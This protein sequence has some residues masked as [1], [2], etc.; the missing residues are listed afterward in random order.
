MAKPGARSRPRRGT[1]KLQ[2]TDTVRTYVTQPIGFVFGVFFGVFVAGVVG[3][4]L[5]DRLDDEQDLRYLPMVGASL[6]LMCSHLGWFIGGIIER[7]EIARVLNEPS[8]GIR[9]KWSRR[10]G[11]LGGTAGICAWFTVWEVLRLDSSAGLVLLVVTFTL[12]L[13]SGRQFGR[14]VDR[15]W[16]NEQERT[17][18]L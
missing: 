3:A 11:F 12:A 18:R 2:A 7:S 9:S 6:L 16:E 15:R 17:A 13:L 4:F 1:D 8:F 10:L 5:D 14:I